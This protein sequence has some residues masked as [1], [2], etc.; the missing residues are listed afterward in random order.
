MAAVLHHTHTPLRAHGWADVGVCSYG[1]SRTQ[2]LTLSCSPT[3]TASAAARVC[4]RGP[5]PCPRTIFFIAPTPTCARHIHTHAC[6]RRVEVAVYTYVAECS[7][8]FFIRPRIDSYF[9]STPL[10]GTLLFSVHLS[11]FPSLESGWGACVLKP[12]SCSK[13]REEV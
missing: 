12:W 7:Y 2:V 13:G 6:R 10:F 3:G 9:G 5:P 4:A 1:C 8:T 11:S